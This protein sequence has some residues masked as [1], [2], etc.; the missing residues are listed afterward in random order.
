M[1]AVADRI[2]Y[3]RRHS[4]R[5]WRETSQQLDALPGELAT[6]LMERFDDLSTPHRVFTQIPDPDGNR[7]RTRVVD[8][9]DQAHM[10]TAAAARKLRHV[11]QLASSLDDDEI[12]RRAELAARTCGRMRTVEQRLAYAEQ[13]GV[14][15]PTGQNVTKRGL[16][17]RLLAADWWKRKFRRLWG[18]RTED[19]LREALLVHEGR[20]PYLSDLSARR[21]RQQQ[22]KQVR[23]VAQMDLVEMLTG[24]VLPL[25]KVAENSLA[26]PKNRN[27]EMMTHARGCQEFATKL[28]H[29]GVMVT[30]TCPSR[31]HAVLSKS[32]A[33]NPNFDGST[34]RDGQRWLSDTWARVRAE[35]KRREIHAYGWRVAEPHHDG[36]PH[37]HLLI[38]CE[39]R[40]LNGLCYVL[41]QKWFREA[42]DEPGAEK[43]RLQ[44]TEEDASRGSAVGY[45]AMYI[46]KNMAGGT[47]AFDA[48]ETDN[49]ALDF[50]DGAARA[51]AW[52]RTH[53]IRQFQS[54]GQPVKALW[55]EVRRIMEPVE[56][57]DPVVRLLVNNCQKTDQGGA[58]TWAGIFA[59]LGGHRGV[60]RKSKCLLAYGLPRTTDRQGR[61]VL[62]MS[63][64]AEIPARRPVG[65]CINVG[66]RFIRYDTRPRQFRLERRSGSGSDS[67][68]AVPL[69]PVAI[70]VRTAPGRPGGEFE[71]TLQRNTGPPS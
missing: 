24:E 39:R 56:T 33:K 22:A 64:W 67:G 23:A 14:E 11:K 9:W 2:L 52:A 43:H 59:I 38:Y 8:S 12:E 21:Y 16:N 10:Q 48:K 36:T 63:K 49:S 61:S 54:F 69:G 42:Y 35:L 66:P 50:K 53:G 44:I 68:S 30:G 40:E 31:F 19:A 57:L 37:W 4:V 13:H 47:E 7:L 32:R 45:L 3:D 5:D 60:N 26:N 65:L 20:A 41:E 29:V 25:K 46:A 6:A 34:V 55:R 27:A 17:A 58:P 1:D 62:R 15:V 28:G 70:T 71:E 18:Q 51:V